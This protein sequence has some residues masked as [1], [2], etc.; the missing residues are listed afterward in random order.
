MSRCVCS[1]MY[2][3]IAAACLQ[4]IATGQEHSARVGLADPSESGGVR[5]TAVEYH[6]EPL[7]LTSAVRRWP[8][9]R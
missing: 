8:S 7:P 4:F 1:P 2:S 6:L 5:W 3:M 9:A